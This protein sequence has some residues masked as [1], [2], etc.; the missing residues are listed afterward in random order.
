MLRRFLN[1]NQQRIKF[2]ALLFAG[3]LS[4]SLLAAL[5]AARTVVYRPF[6]ET[7]GAWL[8]FTVGAFVITTLALFVD[9]VSDF[10]KRSKILTQ[11]NWS[12]FFEKFDFREIAMDKGRFGY[13][14]EA[15]QGQVA[16]FNVI[17]FVNLRDKAVQ[18]VFI[19]R[20]DKN[21]K[22]KFNYQCNCNLQFTNL[23]MEAPEIEKIAID[24]LNEIQHSGIIASDR[25]TPN[26]VVV[27]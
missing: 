1:I 4:I 3:L 16:N 24:F 26:I 13:K 15:K 27:K 6:S 8:L 5:L 9:G 12:S 17:A 7:L 10:N 23:Q 25:T 21:G 14:Q 20:D 19:G 2:L 22:A 11:T 18:F